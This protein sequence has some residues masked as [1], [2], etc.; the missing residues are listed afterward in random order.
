VD[1]GEMIDTTHLDADHPGFT[2]AT[3]RSRRDAIA[4]ASQAVPPGGPPPRVEYTDDEHAL[5]AEVSRALG[6]RH[7]RYACEE[8]RRAASALD[9]PTHVVPQ[10]ADVS[11]RLGELTSFRIAAVPGLVPT[12]VFYGSLA[13]RCFLS[14]QY[15]RHGSEPFYT[16]EPDVIHELIGH[17]NSLASPRIA[18][19]YER[20]GQVACRLSHPALAEWLGRVFWFTLE[21]GVVRERGAYRTYGAGLLSSFGEIQHFRDAQIRPFDVHDMRAFDDYEISTFQEVLF[22]AD[23]FDDAE[24][25]LLRFFDELLRA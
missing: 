12:R 18:A 2:D 21:F 11:T 9:L 23:S 4:A 13:E 24:A 8:Y 3:Y 1:V 6:E 20:A 14:T 10:L 16:P 7:A 17:A 22:A 15:L 19:L 25:R 5:W